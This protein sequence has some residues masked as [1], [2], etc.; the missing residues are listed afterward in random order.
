MA[1]SRPAEGQSLPLVSG[2]KGY[3]PVS[4]KERRFEKA[5]PALTSTF[6]ERTYQFSSAAAKAAFDQNPEAYAPAYG[7]VDPVEWLE[8]QRL[9]EGQF[10]REYDGRFYLF[11]SKENWE[12]FKSQPARFVL[13]SELATR[14]LVAR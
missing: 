14:H 13:T 1:L 9:V 12:I 6:E 4:L 10:L 2:L 11:A 7:G 8:H 5:N 3:C